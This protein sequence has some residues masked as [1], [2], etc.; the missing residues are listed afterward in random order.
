MTL[1]SPSRRRF[2]MGTALAVAALVTAAPV[3]AAAHDQV[4]WQNPVADEHLDDSPEQI[5]LSFTAE[6][7]PVGAVMMVVGADG[8]AY[9][10]GDPTISGS[11]VSQSL[12]GTLPDGNYQVRWRVVSSD[13][14]PISE[15]ILFSVGDVSD[16]PLVPEPESGAEPVTD[17]EQP[18]ATTT[19][20]TA[21][22]A[23]GA[24]LRTALVAGGG[25]L[26]GL[27]VFLAVRLMGGRRA[28]AEKGI[29]R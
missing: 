8:T 14:H 7:L 21:D 1:V 16:A 4:V 5:V 6:P 26:A 3:P 12:V 29:E 15:S 9:E 20:A 17:A 25:A 18:A 22:Q 11:E 27:A 10:A 23:D 2:A 28:P 24:V 13:G 19:A